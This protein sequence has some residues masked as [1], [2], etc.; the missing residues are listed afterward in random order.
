MRR[1]SDLPTVRQK[2]SYGGRGWIYFCIYS[3]RYNQNY[4]LIAYT[5][6]Y[7]INYFILTCLHLLEFSF[8]LTNWKEKIGSWLADKNIHLKLSFWRL[9]NFF[10]SNWIEYL[11][12]V[13]TSEPFAFHSHKLEKMQ[14]FW[15]KDCTLGI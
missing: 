5:F 4:F 11:W 3:G 6:F 7:I 1:L 8:Y 12:P 15:L 13:S 10:F 14:W 2:L 9:N